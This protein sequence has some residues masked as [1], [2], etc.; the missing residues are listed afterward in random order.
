MTRFDLNPAAWIVAAALALSACSPAE[1]P[2][3][4]AAGPAAA[5]ADTAPDAAALA[6]R[7]SLDAFR[8]HVRTLSSDEFGGRAP[9]SEGEEKTVEY[10]VAEFEALGLRGGAADGGF[11]QAVPVVGIEA[12]NFS[13]LRIA[14]RES[15]LSVDVGTRAVAWTKRVTESVDVS[16]SPLVFVG[17]G[18]VAPEYGW[19]DYAGVDVR[20]K[21]VVMLVN[22]PGFASGDDALFNGRAMTYYG[23]WTYKFDEAARQG[24]TGA[25]LV[26]ETDPAGYPWDV[27]TGSWLGEQFDLVTEDRNMGRTAFESWIDRSFAE[28]LFA[29]VGR[30]YEAARDAAGKPGHRA[31]E[32][33]A[34][35]S[36]SFE[37]ELETSVTRNVIARLDGTSAADEVIGYSAHWDHLGTAPAGDG[38]RIFNGAADNATGVAA[39]LELARILSDLPPMPRSHVFIA[40][41]AEESGLLGSAWFASNPSVDLARMAGL[42][43]IDSMTVLGPTND[44]TVIGL[45]SS[46]LEELLASA[47]AEQGRRLEREPTPE[48][49]FFYRSDHFNFAREGVPVL[50]AEGGVEHRERGREYGMAY[51]AD[52][53][54]NRYHKP[55]DEYDPDWDLRGVAEDIGLYAAIGLRLSQPGVWPNWYEG[56]EF[57]ARRDD[58]AASRR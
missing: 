45:G 37:N 51:N 49:G 30:D 6:E 5:A 10:L 50:Y 54:A 43:N 21:T 14:A 41:A 48:K 26:H 18:V 57:R 28:A 24:A 55:G 2:A 29:A 52:Y 20:G 33:G 7:V 27:V 22:D 16:D 25:I 36:L 31:F 44:V 4:K 35:V 46:Q 13:P 1:S 47:A 15:T 40:L 39:L 38:D 58:T 34:T 19:D 56:N 23:R 3:G 8:E 17:Y 9:A 11:E 32:M 42:I 53:V 12:R